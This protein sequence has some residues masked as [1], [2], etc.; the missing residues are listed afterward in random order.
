MPPFFA[1]IIRQNEAI[2]NKKISG[3]ILPLDTLGSTNGCMDPLIE[4]PQYIQQAV[5]N[6]YGFR[7]YNDTVLAYTTNELNK[8]DGCTDLIGQCRELAQISDPD[9]DGA[10]QTV[11]ALC[12]AAFLQCYSNVQEPFTESGVSPTFLFSLRLLGCLM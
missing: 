9:Y 8:V 1:L 7:G 11:N 3:R 2:R 6:T 10:N 12:S 4:A 5:N